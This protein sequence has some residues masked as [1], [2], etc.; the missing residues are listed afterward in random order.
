MLA[1]HDVRFFLSRRHIGGAD[2]WHDA[3]GDALKRCDWF[4]VVLSPEAVRSM[5]VKRELLYA[6]RDERLHSRIIPALYK[7]CDMGSLSWTLP[8]LQWVDFRGNFEEGSRQLLKIW[9]IPQ[10]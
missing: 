2:E 9:K 8:A 1:A 3:I 5:W 10:R 6:L 4:L 7:T